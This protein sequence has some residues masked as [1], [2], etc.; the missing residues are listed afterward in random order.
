[1]K[2]FFTKNGMLLLTAITVLAV[3]LCVFSAASSGTGFVHN[4]LGVIASPFRAV[5]SAVSGWVTGIGDRFESLEDLQQENQELRRENEELRRQLRQAKEDS[6]ENQR[7]RN[8]LNLRQQRQ[9]FVFESANVVGLGS[10]NWSSTLT[11]SKGSTCDIAIGDCVVSDEGYRVGVVTE[12]GLNWSTVSTILDTQSQL[13]AI[14]FRTG[15]A[16][17]AQGDLHLMNQ[18]LLKLSFLED[19]ASLINGDLIVTSGLGGY[20]PSDLVIGTVEEI[21]RDDAGAGEFAV[22]APSAALDTLEEVFI[23]K[24]F[25]IVD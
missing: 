6:E 3:L 18:G 17:V 4:A 5:G 22:I 25:E 14:V 2:K 23:I 20:Y 10:S 11:L 13:G 15:E 12:V 19:E 21:R 8:L 9:D 7:L 24:S 16:T 1:M